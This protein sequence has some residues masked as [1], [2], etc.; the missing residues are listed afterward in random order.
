MLK[1]IQNRRISCLV[2]PLSQLEWSPTE[3]TALDSKTGEKY[4]IAL[5]PTDVVKEALLDFDYP[6]SGIRIKDIA[7]ALA[8]QFALTKKQRE[9][10]EK[11]GL[12]WRFHVNMAAVDLVN[13]RQLLRIKRGWITNPDST[14]FP[15][16][17][18]IDPEHPDIERSEP[19]ESPFSDGDTPSPEVVIAQ[20]HEKTPRQI[21]GRASAKHY[22][23]PARF[24]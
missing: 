3:K 9:A 12:V 23:Q 13:S 14:L 22:R 11:Y 21:E 24:F 19:D 20:N 7:E 4:Q 16:D 18:I 6:P 2:N 1:A 10:K 5:P 8:D 15:V 17:S